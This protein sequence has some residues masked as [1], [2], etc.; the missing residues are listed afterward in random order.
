MTSVTPIRPNSRN[1]AG[2]FALQ[3]VGPESRARRGQK[4]ACHYKQTPIA[5][6]IDLF[7]SHLP[8]TAHRPI[9]S[10]LRSVINANIL[11]A[12]MQ[13]AFV[14]PTLLCL[15]LQAIRLFRAFTR[16]LR[17]KLPWI[18]T[19]ANWISSICRMAAGALP[20]QLCTQ[21]HGRLLVPS[22]IGKR[23]MSFK[24]ATDLRLVGTRSLRRLQIRRFAILS[25]AN[26][27]QSTAETIIRKTRCQSTS[28]SGLSATG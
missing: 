18:P 4:G 11:K 3:P 1:T 24:Q 12:L 28:I 7:E 2:S 21:Q 26:S 5:R 10:R 15:V 8:R 16:S 20:A 27:S 19:T 13:L 6:E 17:S 23:T 22:Q 14:S 25:M 9:R